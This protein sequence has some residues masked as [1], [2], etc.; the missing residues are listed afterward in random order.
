MTTNT[1]E[2]QKTTQNSTKQCKKLEKTTKTT[3]IYKWLQKVAI[4]HKR[5]QNKLQKNELQNTQQKTTKKTLTKSTTSYQN[6]FKTNY[7]QATRGNIH[8]SSN[9]QPTRKAS[10][11]GKI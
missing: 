11:L 4:N 10:N 8:A 3:N 1:N 6:T 5:L 2:K 7:T 9:M